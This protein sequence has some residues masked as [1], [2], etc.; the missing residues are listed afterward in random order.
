MFR[1][2]FLG[3]GGSIP[4]TRRNP[5]AVM[6]EFEGDRLLFDCGEGTQ[7]Q[8]MRHGTG[9]GVDAIFVS[10]LHGDHVLGI[11]GLIQ[12][13]S[14]QG[15]D[16][17]LTIYG[18]PGSTSALRDCVHLTGHEPD[19]P[20]T[21]TTLADGDAVDRSGYTVAAVGTEHD[22]A[23]SVGY[24][25]REEERKGRF[26]REAALDLGVPEGPLFSRLHDGE[27][28]ELD[29]GTVVEPEDVVGEP[30]RGRSM[31]YTGDTRPTERVVAAAEDAELLVHDGM[32]ADDMEDRAR[33]TGHST[34]REAA[35]VA[36][37]AGVE[38]LA[39]THVSSRYAD[40]VDALERE[41]RDRFAEAVVAEDGTEIV[42]E[43]PEKDRETRVVSG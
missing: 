4:Q 42:V 7:R 34:A 38:L 22:A 41:A 10:H 37:R 29:D 30:R 12:T 3:T 33:R 35:D 21:V 40:G 17:P 18:P 8:M 9:F 25:L 5:S 11:P 2:T 14:F 27:T 20:V 23:S 36:A 32:F 19:Y 24:A 15:R 1:V 6:V 39:L 16:A 31:V 43:Y 13:W 26:D 28:V